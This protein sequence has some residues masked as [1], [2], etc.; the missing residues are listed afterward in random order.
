[1]REYVVFFTALMAV[2]LCVQPASAAVCS[3]RDKFKAFLETK[4]GEKAHAF[5]K[6]S[7]TAVMELYVS[8]SG[9]WTVLM[10]RANGV[11]CLIAAGN[12]FEQL[13]PPLP[14]SPS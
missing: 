14:G 9:T 1:M 6:I 2:F 12:N 7:G 10:T 13:K 3:Q 4:Y 11:S 8:K 5:G